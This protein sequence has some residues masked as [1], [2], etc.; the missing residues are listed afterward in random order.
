M[1]LKELSQYVNRATLVRLV[2]MTD[3]LLFEGWADF[4]KWLNAVGRYGN[5]RIITMWTTDNGYL[6][7]R[8]R[9]FK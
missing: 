8:L 7:I 5:H 9:C 2:S 6:N 4:E 1:T 3:E